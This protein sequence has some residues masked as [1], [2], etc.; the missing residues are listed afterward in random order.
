MQ[1]KKV[2]LLGNEELSSI[3]DLALILDC[4]QQ[5]PQPEYLPAWF[6]Y[7]AKNR[8]PSV[9]FV[10]YGNAFYPFHVAKKNL[11]EYSIDVPVASQKL[12]ASQKL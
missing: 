5:C 4:H 2:Y 10:A 8:V 11:N 3:L 1:L 7:T 6:F 9:H 12:Y